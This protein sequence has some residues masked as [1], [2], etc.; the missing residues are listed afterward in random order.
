MAGLT[1]DELPCLLTPIPGPRSRAWVD[2][3]AQHEC[4]AITSRRSRRASALG[5]AHADPIVWEEAAGAVIRDADGNKFVDMTSG[6]AVALVGHR[7]PAV[8]A[9]VR[10]Q[11]DRLLHAMGDAFPD[12]TRIRLLQALAQ[13]C[14]GDLEVS[15]L[16]LSGSDAVEAAVKTAVLATGR[17][18]VV[19]FDGSYHG[20]SLGTVA[21]QGYKDAFLKPFVG[22]AHPAVTKLPWGCGAEVLRT[23]L[24]AGD[25]GLVLLEPIQGRGGVR[26]P[27]DGWLAE[28][29]QLARDAGALVAHDA[30]QTGLGR[31]GAW[32][33]GEARG[34]VPDL[35]CVGKA[36]GGGFPLSAC[37]GTREVM[38][39]WGASTGEALHTQTFLGHPVGCAAGLAVLG[40]LAEWDA[41][42]RASALE[43]EIRGMM[44]VPVRGAGAM[45]AAEV[46]GAAYAT[47]LALLR[48]GFLC[49]PVGSDD[50]AVGIIPPLTISGAQLTAFAAAFDEA[51]AE[52]EA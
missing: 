29:A 7:H 19:T 47:C 27:P 14:P 44:S 13:R 45:L 35:L 23:R 2:V 15:I 39:A 9:A 38:D 21:L 42:A 33:A 11:Q 37:V 1:G 32:W 36:L 25:I 10:S 48:R 28:V 50:R 31:T 24:A 26:L 3:L 30:I 51:R 4:P 16:G 43:G 8:V 49:L 22:V 12:V 40:L 18:G 5:L 34:V 41:P 6:F 20:L 17:T 52:V 46:P